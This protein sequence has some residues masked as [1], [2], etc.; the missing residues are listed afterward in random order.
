MVGAGIV[1]SYFLFF[2]QSFPEV[3]LKNYI[4]V[5][6]VMFVALVIIG[7]LF[8]R[9]WQ[10]DLIKFVNLKLNGHGADIDLTIKAQRKI[11]NLPHVSSLVSMFNW[12]LAAITMT[13]YNFIDYTESSLTEIIFSSLRTFVG[14]II[15]GT[16]TCAIIFFSVEI[17]CRK[18]WPCFF[19]DG[20]LIK[21]AGVIRLKLRSRM[22]IIFVLASL[23]P[24]ILMAVLSYNKAQLMLQMPPADV[25]G[26]LLYLTAFLMV[27]ALATAIILSHI[28][29]TSIIAP[30]RQME[31][32]M[33]KV[34]AGNFKTRVPIHSNDELGALAEHFNQM[35]VGLQERYRLRRSLDLAKEVQQ[36]LL[37]KTDPVVAGL[38]IAGQSIYCDETGGDYFDYLDSRELG[39]QKFAVLVGDVSGHGI[40]SALLMATARAFIRQRTT[41]SGS[42]AEVVSDVNR[43]LT[44]DVEETGRFMTLFYLLIDQ[45]DRNLQWVRAGHDPALCYDPAS[46]CFDELRGSGIALG[47]DDGWHYTAYEKSGL[48][49]GQIILLSTDGIWETRNPAG[50]M[51]GKDPI[52]KIIRQKSEAAAGE[53]VASI[54]AELEHF[55]QHGQPADDIT[56]VVIKIAE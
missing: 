36:N 43:Q 30:V 8:F 15:A 4:V 52:H 31:A 35:T 49:K 5:I 22:L 20:G 19:P 39:E 32:A 33:V 11:L 40:P 51:F 14:V 12:F 53:I 18:I 27:V 16:V 56:L 23:L 46:D 10:K 37:P 7:T 2:E 13:T 26:S 1:T 24:I 47:V 54:I 17:F 3:N 42:I 9:Y 45:A 55:R 44:R 38:D 48:K 50:N 29:A 41:R 28:F 21:A 25:I 34:E 6:G